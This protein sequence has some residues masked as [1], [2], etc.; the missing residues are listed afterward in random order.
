M[1]GRRITI[2]AAWLL[3]AAAGCNKQSV[4]GDPNPATLPPAPAK[5]FPDVSKYFGK[6]AVGPAGTPA[7]AVVIKEKRKPGEGLKPET[8]VALAQTEVEAAY[9]EGRTAGERD[10]LLDSA[11]QRYQRALKAKPKDQDA[12]LGLARLYVKAGDKERADATYRT[13]VELYP[14]DHG[15]AHRMAGAKAQ[16]GDWD[17]AAEACQL[18]LATDPENRTYQ[19]TLA[20]CLAGAGRWDESFAAAS[21]IMPEAEAR[22]FLGRVLYDQDKHAEARQMMELAVRADPRLEVAQR[23]L[24]D[25]DAVAKAAVAADGSVRTVGH[26]EPAAAEGGK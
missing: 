23:F 9:A 6:N 13:A 1:D 20:F 2:G 12:L 21:K 11:R 7:E 18:A 4:V 17:G 5:Q 22:Y 26:Q 25:L 19:K 8:E 16:F 14:K 10:Q 24:T 3:A 15:L